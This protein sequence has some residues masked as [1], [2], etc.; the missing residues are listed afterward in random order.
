MSRAIASSNVLLH[1]KL[2]PATIVFSVESGKILYVHE[3]LLEPSDELLTIYNIQDYQDV[4]PHVVMPG[5]VD[6]HVHLNEPGRTEWEGFATGTKAA[7]AG[8]VTTVVDMPLNAIPPT[9]T[10]ENFQLKISAARNQC[11]VD[12]GFWG[13]MIPSNLNHL[14]PLIRMGVRGFKGFLIES[15]VEEFPHIDPEYVV[16]AMQ[17][18]AAHS[19]VLMFH[20]E[21]DGEFQDLKIAEDSTSYSS[22]LA[23]RPDEFETSAIGEIIKCLEQYPTVPLHVVH[24]ATHKAVPMIKQAQAAGLPISAETCFHYLSLCSEKIAKCSTQFKCCPPIREEDN[25]RKLW[26]ALR[27]DVITT[28]VLDHSPC[29]PDLKRLEKG[30]FF[31]AWGGIASVGL[32]LPIIYTEG[33]RQDTPVTFAEINKW[34]SVNT[35]KQTGLDHRKGVF[36]V[37]YDADI[38]VF[39]TT[40]T[41]RVANNDVHFKNKL[42]AYDGVEL[43]GRVVETVVRGNTVYL[44]GQ[45]HS[46]VPKGSLLLEP[47]G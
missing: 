12:V 19:T 18:V 4:S 15:G 47:R 32:G 5:L 28:V 44:H 11:W 23:L 37:G 7:A 26:D 14:E 9:T 17:K 39:D 46:E 30:D 10:V 21:M 27:D 6:A 34:C 33:L 22:F 38:L 8:G 43:H 36:K 45:G 25:R 35:A 40:Q 3:D 20:A 31:E 42:T 24:L 1:D 29:T 41:Y 13:G 16:K 2:V